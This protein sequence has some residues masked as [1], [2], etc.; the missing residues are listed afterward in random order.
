[1]P[2]TG[3]FPSNEATVRPASLTAAGSPGPLVR[4][5][6]CGLR[7]STSRGGK[8]AGTTV[9]N[10]DPAKGPLGQLTS[11]FKNTPQLPFEE[12]KLHFFEGGRA[13]LSTPPYC[14]TYTTKAN[15]VPWSGGPEKE[16]KEPA[17]AR[18]KARR[19]FVNVV[20]VAFFTPQ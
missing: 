14:G 20:C 9:P 6:P 2:N 12:L 10:A 13:S 18:T 19:S 15:F 11:T 8:L 7:A 3:I 1:M 17:P 4:K 5:T 16:P